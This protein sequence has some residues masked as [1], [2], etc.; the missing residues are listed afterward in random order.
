MI[1]TSVAILARRLKRCTCPHATGFR[2]AGPAGGGDTGRTL[3]AGQYPVG[4]CRL[5]A[6]AVAPTVRVSQ[7]TSSLTVDTV[8]VA[9]RD[10]PRRGAPAPARRAA[11]SSRIP[12]A[13]PGW[14]FGSFHCGE[15]DSAPGPLVPD[16]AADDVD[17]PVEHYD[18]AESKP[19]HDGDGGTGGSERSSSFG[20]CGPEEGSE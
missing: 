1:L 3:R 10:A 12:R 11:A 2:H 16:D 20:S 6:D 18:S 8:D 17:D 4:L 5:W 15:L 19:S 7:A 13:P 9:L 14:R